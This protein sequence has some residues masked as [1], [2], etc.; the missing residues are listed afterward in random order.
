[1][2]NVSSNTMSNKYCNSPVWGQT[3]SV[4]ESPQC[5]H[6]TYSSLRHSVP[7]TL[8]ADCQHCLVKIGHSNYLLRNVRLEL[9]YAKKLQCKQRNLMVKSCIHS[10]E[11]AVQSPLLE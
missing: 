2:L 9:L 5:T 1:M 8:Q 3:Y 4:P 7:K 6:W 10:L 11:S